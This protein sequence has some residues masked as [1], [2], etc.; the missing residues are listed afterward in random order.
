MRRGGRHHL[1]TSR[2]QAV[3]RGFRRVGGGGESRRLLFSLLGG[4]GM[5]WVKSLYVQRERWT[6]LSVRI[7]L[8]FSVMADCYWLC[9]N[10][11]EMIL[12][13]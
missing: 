9:S 8:Q 13:L 5:F 7:V 11:N 3:G 10:D 6:P 2:R 4:I 1:R 12:V